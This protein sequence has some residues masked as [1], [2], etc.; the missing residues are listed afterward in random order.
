MNILFVIIWFILLP[1]LESN[2]PGDT[3]F[4]IIL[5]QILVSLKALT[6]APLHILPLFL[7][8]INISFGWKITCAIFRKES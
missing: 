4:F 6:S 8:L 1:I 2:K 7:C 5:K 3:V